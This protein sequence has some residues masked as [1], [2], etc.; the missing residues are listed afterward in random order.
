MKCNA[1][2]D[3]MKDTQFKLK[4][5]KSINFL[6]RCRYESCTTPSKKGIINLST[7]ALSDDEAIVLPHGLNHGIPSSGIDRKEVF[8]VFEFEHLE[9]SS[10]GNKDHVSASLTQLAHPFPVRMQK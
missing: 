2:L 6:S 5:Q 9:P 7:C 4:H 10:K 3:K 8:S 1:S